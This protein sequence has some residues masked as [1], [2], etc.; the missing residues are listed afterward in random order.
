MLDHVDADVAFVDDGFS[1]DGQ[2]VLAGVG[3]RHF[4]GAIAHFGKAD[5]LV[6]AQGGGDAS[7]LLALLKQSPLH[8]TYGDTL[9]NIVATGLA[10]VTFGLDLPLHGGLPSKIDGTV[11]LAGARLV[12]KRWDI[13]FD[14]VRGSARYAGNGF[15]AD[16]LSV[17]HDGQPGRLSLRAGDFTRDR[18]Q[19]FE[20]GLDATVEADDL[21]QRAPQLAWLKPYMSGRSVWT[22]GVAIP[23]STTGTAQPSHLQL[24]SDLVGTSLDLPAPLRKPAARHL[25]ANIETALPFGTGETTC[26]SGTWWR[27]ARTAA[28][29]TGV[30]VAFGGKHAGIR[31]CL[32][33]VRRWACIDARCAR[34]GRHRQRWNR[35]R[36]RDAAARYRHH[37]GPV[38]RRG[39]GVPRHSTPGASHRRGPRRTSAGRRVRRRR[40]DSRCRWRHGDGSVPARVLA[41]RR[42]RQHD[43]RQCD[44]RE[45][46]DYDGAT[47]TRMSIPPGSRRCRWTSPSCA[48]A[49]PGSARRPA[50]ACA[51]Q[52]HA[53][54]TV[55][56]RTR[57]NASISAAN[58]SAVAALRAR[59]WRPPWTATTSARC[60]RL[61][62]RR[63]AQRGRGKARID[64]AG[65]EARRHFRWRSSPAR[66]KIAAREGQLVELEPGAGRVL[67]LLS[68]AQL[69]RRLRSTSM[70]S[71][72]RA[73]PS[74]RSM[75][76]CV[77]RRTGPQRQPRHR[78]A[79]SGDPHPRLGEPGRPAVRPDH[80]RLP[81]G[82]QPADGRRCDRRW[83]GGRRHRRG[84]QRRAQEAAGTT[85]GQ[86]L[87]GDRPVEGTEGRGHQPRAIAARRRSPQRATN[88]T[89]RLIPRGRARS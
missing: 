74:T 28:R 41:Q 48:S 84:R 78:R 35:R 69:P 26:R 10:N 14:N 81:Q 76:T 8:K 46:D 39:F 12:E 50:H 18:R 55:R 66:S 59:T 11:A 83:A 87:S 73:S 40:A 80:R 17:V 25:S 44:R 56:T 68:I 52:R 72:R 75:A 79:G 86:D 36:Q 16:R 43:R 20:A 57:T 9:D 61:R 63:P 6:H 89:G 29:T 34:L 42:G 67:G 27:C 4:D 82:R 70:I 30:R 3:I 33:I 51:G 37:R 5:L 23:R 32:R 1:I 22:V 13:A 49:M 15:Q 60:C 24:H 88:A 47:A 21:M 65:R 54:R 53:H 77:S 58:G 71:S 7:R 62:L 2:G 85:R 19:A 45:H 64:A 38:D 31:T